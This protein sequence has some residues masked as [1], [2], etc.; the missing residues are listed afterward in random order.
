[1]QGILN[2]ETPIQM[3]KSGALFGI[4]TRATASREIGVLILNA[5]LLHHVGPFRLHVLLAR[6]LGERGFTS[7]RMDQSGKGESFSRPDKAYAE[8]ILED[9]DDAMSILRH[10]GVTSTV[11]VGLCS[12]ADDALQIAVARDSV[13]GL[14]MLDGYAPKGPSYYFRHY[15]RRIGKPGVWLRFFGRWRSARRPSA[16]E[17]PVSLALGLRNWKPQPEMLADIGA[18]LERGTRLMAVFTGGVEDYYNHPRQLS[19]CFPEFARSGRLQ[20][21]YFSDAEHVYVTVG[22]RERLLLRLG[23]WFSDT[24]QADRPH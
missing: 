2:N 17:P 3:G 13:A 4:L 7:L 12:G 6:L 23:H 5:G 22:Q 16:E 20:E 14:V 1:V 18:L 15:S 9:Y 8:A 11:L 21:D 10:H 24:F 19:R